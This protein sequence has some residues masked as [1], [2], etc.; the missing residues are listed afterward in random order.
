MKKLILALI[1]GCF[2]F[3]GAQAQH[4]TSRIPSAGCTGGQLGYY[5]KQYTTPATTRRINPNAFEYVLK[6][7]LNSNRTD[8]IVT[9]NAYRGDRLTIIYCNRAT[10]DT[11]TFGAVFTGDGTAYPA[12]GAST[13]LSSNRIPIPASK[14]ATIIFVFDGYI[15]RELSH[16]I[17]L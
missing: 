2:S 9:V 7:T 3:I 15:W 4:T 11:V 12:S 5:Y 17:S 13:A 6:D 1:I 8:S 16:A 14:V 10:A